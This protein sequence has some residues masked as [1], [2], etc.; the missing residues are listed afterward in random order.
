MPSA[1]LTRRATWLLGFKKKPSLTN[2]VGNPKKKAKATKGS[3][4]FFLG[5]PLDHEICQ[6]TKKKRKPTIR[7][8]PQLQCMEDMVTPSHTKIMYT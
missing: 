3:V 8:L 5:L 2:L 1:R 6:R 4:A 7:W